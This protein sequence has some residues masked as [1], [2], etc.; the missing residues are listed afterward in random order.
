MKPSRVLLA[1]L[2]VALVGHDGRPAV[3]ADASDDSPR[4]RVLLDD[5]WQFRRGE[6]DLDERAGDVSWAPVTLP[7][8]W[9]AD[10]VWDD[11]PGYYRGAGWYRRRVHTDATLAG[12]RLHLHFEGVGQAADV[13][14]NGVLAGRHEGGYTAFTVDVTGHLRPGHAEG[15][16]VAVRADNAERAHLPPLSGDFNFY[17]GIYRDVWLVATSPIHLATD[18]HGSGGVFVDTPEVSD[19]RATVRVRGTVVNDTDRV[20]AVRVVASIARRADHGGRSHTAQD[21][22]A[23]ASAPLRIASADR[24]S[25]DVRIPVVAPERWTVGTHGGAP[26]A[27]Y[28]ARVE[29]LDDRG[30]VL[31]RVDATFGIRTLRFDPATGF[32][33]NGERLVLRGTNRHQDRDG[34]GNALPDAQHVADLTA[35]REMGANF[36]RLAHYP[37]DPAVLDAADRLGLLVWEEIPIVDKVTPS[38][39]F[40]DTARRMLTEMIRQHYNHPSIAIWGYMNEVLQKLPPEGDERDRYVEWVLGLARRLDAIARSEDPARATALAVE[41]RD[42]YETSGLGDVPQVLGFNLYHGWYY[43]TFADFGRFLD[44]K[45]QRYASTTLMVSEYGADGD[46]RLHSRAPVRYDYSAEYQRLLHEA[47]LPQIEARAYLAGGAVWVQND[48]A[49]EHRGESFPHRN[50]KGLARHDRSPKDVYFLYQ[51]RWQ[52]SPVLHIATSDAP[53]RVVTVRQRGAPAPMPVTVYSNCTS[54]S[55]THNGRALQGQPPGGSVA[56]YWNVPFADGRNTLV[57]RGECAGRRI[58]KSENVDVRVV[59]PGALVLQKGEAWAV[60]AGSASQYR[61]ADGVLWS[62]DRAYSGDTWGYE[63]GRGV[64]RTNSPNVRGTADDPLFQSYRLGPR[65]YRF[66]VPDG[67]YELEVRAVEPD[68]RVGPGGRVFELRVDGRPDATVVDLAAEV[69]AWVAT[70]RTFEVRAA[71]GRGVRLVFTPMAGEPVVSAIKLTRR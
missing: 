10:D 34:L 40:E 12:R 66:A 59:E 3:R 33:L 68:R 24:A 30:A 9:N 45:R 64:E 2:A 69:G 37:Q 65:S 4:L 49:A 25:F 42:V 70:T 39:E 18:D 57:A 35:I 43:G 23:S 6:A 51:A 47:Y 62:A 60:N 5:G 14:V 26:P 1:A 53:A 31:D 54:V 13:F 27:L 20:G 71:G 63:G 29:V 21:G 46:P 56:S 8:T 55:L 38:P 11:E 17:G 36:V 15:D 28:V 22:G 7:H 44:R 19:A 50:Q 48:F 61:D 32:W 67:D 16:L 58:E 41:S 52:P